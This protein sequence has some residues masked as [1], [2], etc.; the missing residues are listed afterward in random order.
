MPD[1]PLTWRT[2][3]REKK[4][5]V[6]VLAVRRERR[7]EYE[8]R[9]EPPAARREVRP[10]E[11]AVGLRSGRRWTGGETLP[12][13]ALAREP[14]LLTPKEPRALRREL[15]RPLVESQQVV[16]AYE[17]PELLPGQ[18]ALHQPGARQPG[19]ALTEYWRARRLGQSVYQIGPGFRK[20]TGIRV[21]G[22]TNA[23][24]WRHFGPITTLS[25]GCSLGGKAHSGAALQGVDAGEDHRPSRASVGLL[26][27]SRQDA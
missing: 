25:G 17:M 24:R 26:K 6:P 4:A 7:Y 8:E 1:H 9:Y 16:S 12:A 2:Y 21:A 14:I 20:I 23:G 22:S 18:H 10:F 11:E 15:A 5:P 13:G 3:R 27:T 19:P